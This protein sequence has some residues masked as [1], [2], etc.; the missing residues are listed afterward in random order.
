MRSDTI[1][2]HIVTILLD[3][4]LWL[5]IEFPDEKVEMLSSR[6]SLSESVDQNERTVWLRATSV[7]YTSVYT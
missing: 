2:I 3:A 4:I 6:K 7:A 1:L 5:A